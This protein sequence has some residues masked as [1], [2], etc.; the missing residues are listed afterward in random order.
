MPTTKQLQIILR[1]KFAK[2]VLDKN[3]EDFLMHLMSSN[4]SLTLLLLVI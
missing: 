1:K 2:V 3:V 4:S